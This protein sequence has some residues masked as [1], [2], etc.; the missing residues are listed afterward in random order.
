MSVIGDS[1]LPFLSCVVCASLLSCAASPARRKAIAHCLPRTLRSTRQEQ[2]LMSEL[3]AEYLREILHYDRESGVFTWR[4]KPSLKVEI[5][6]RAGTICNG[7]ITIRILGRSYY[8]HRLAWLYIRGRWPKGII[9]HVNRVK[10]D[11]RIAN[12]RDATRSVNCHNVLPR[13]VKSPGAY[14]DLRRGKWGSKIH[15][16]KKRIWLGYHASA[17]LASE[18]YLKAKSRINS[19]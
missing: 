12:L 14:F 5:G 9:D 10:S 18:A 4:I 19:A 1:H 11:N 13:D 6:D 3:T 7:Y 8:A 15:I 16:N 2:V 17:E